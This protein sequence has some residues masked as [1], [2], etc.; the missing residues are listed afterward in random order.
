MCR[1]CGEKLRRLS[2]PRRHALS[3]SLRRRHLQ[4]QS[5]SKPRYAVSFFP[6]AQKNDCQWSFCCGKG[7]PHKRVPKQI[8]KSCRKASRHDWQS[9]TGWSRWNN[10]EISPHMVISVNLQLDVP[11]PLRH[12][13][14]SRVR[15]RRGGPGGFR[16]PRSS[17]AHLR[18]AVRGIPGWYACC[19]S[20]AGSREEL[21]PRV[22]VRQGMSSTVRALDGSPEL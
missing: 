9:L 5:Y 11:G 12:A 3:D 22:K 16:R 2:A 21:W 20:S 14:R 10:A 4:D 6:S 19:E 15:R 7:S 18:P 8:E 1:G 17:S 13:H